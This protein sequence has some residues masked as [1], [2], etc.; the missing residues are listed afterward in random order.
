MKQRKFDTVNFLEA[1]PRL[2]INIGNYPLNARKGVKMEEKEVN[3]QI[4]FNFASEIAGQISSQCKSPKDAQMILR[5]V[6]D[7][8]EVRWAIYLERC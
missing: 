3:E 2:L 1:T 4:V 8:L 6:K 5:L 7:I